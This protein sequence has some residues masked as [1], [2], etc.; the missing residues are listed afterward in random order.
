MMASSSA[1][2]LHSPMARMSESNSL[3]HA[4]TFLAPAITAAES[5][6]V[7]EAAAAPQRFASRCATAAAS[8]VPSATQHAPHLRMKPSQSDT[9]IAVQRSRKVLRCKHAIRGD[10]ESMND[11]A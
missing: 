6:F 1:L 11:A 10:E 2:L 9:Q 4:C 7:A 8:V 3:D 5:S